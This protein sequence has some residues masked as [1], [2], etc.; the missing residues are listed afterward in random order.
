MFGRDSMR[1]AAVDILIGKTARI[2]GD[3]DFAGG[4]HL[5]GRVAGH[6]RADLDSAS[7]LSVSETGWIEGSAQAANV[8]LNGTV[9]GDILAS[10]HVALGPRAKVHGDV[11]YG[12]I[13]TALGAEIL[14]RLVPMAERRS[15]AQGA[16][17][18]GAAADERAVAGKVAAT[19][20]DVAAPVGAVAA[21]VGEVAAAAGEIAAAAGEVVATHPSGPIGLVEPAGPARTA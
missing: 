16:G 19:I 7:T 21:A 3:I 5:D 18:A 14:G 20:G 12:V 15:A 13:E 2:R 9:R 8:I 11:Y 1:P 4:L 10:G 17:K 6:V